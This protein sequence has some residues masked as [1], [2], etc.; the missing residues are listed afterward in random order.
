MRG[1]K[2]LAAFQIKDQLSVERGR[3]RKGR[4][5]CEEER[6]EREMREREARG[7]ERGEGELRER[8][9]GELSERGGELREW[10]GL[11]PRFQK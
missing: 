10:N 7:G 11:N 9:E 6:D 8:G 5:R 2:I 1:L 3:G 4:E